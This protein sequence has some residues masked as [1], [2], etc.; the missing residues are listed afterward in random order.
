MSRLLRKSINMKFQTTE[1]IKKDM[2]K[3][4]NFQGAE[5]LK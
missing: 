4:S 3:Q 2:E 1:K 5:I